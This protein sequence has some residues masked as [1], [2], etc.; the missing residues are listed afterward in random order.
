MKKIL[1]FILT[2][3]LIFVLSACGT[4]PPPQTSREQQLAG[5]G[6]F[7]RH[8]IDGVAKE[9]T[10]SG[11][12]NGGFFLFAAAVNGYIETDTNFVIQ[13]RPEPNDQ[14]Q[15][16]FSRLQIRRIIIEGQ[17]QPEME[18]IWKQLWLIGF[19]SYYSEKNVIRDEYNNYYY[20]EG[21]KLN[22]NNFIKEDNIDVVYIYISPE[23]LLP[24][25]Q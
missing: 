11:Q 16:V 20:T 25:Q 17:D 13:W 12:I 7:G 1:F 18:I 9:Q 23:D 14:I 6:L 8:L 2:L 15:S 3:T 4:P 5:T 24:P 22:L 19:P 10:V 21:S